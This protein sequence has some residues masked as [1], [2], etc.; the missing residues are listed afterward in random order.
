MS[1]TKKFKRKLSGIVKSSNEKTLVVEVTRRFKHKKY[2]KFVKTSKKY[3]AHDESNQGARGDM[4]TIVE[5]KPY[6]KMKKWELLT[7]NKH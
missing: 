4:V 7:I 1:D 5:S 6:S 3:H 2:S